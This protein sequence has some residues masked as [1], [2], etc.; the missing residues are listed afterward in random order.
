MKG[1]C[2]RTIG[3]DH[4]AISHGSGFDP[5]DKRTNRSCCVFSPHSHVGALQPPICTRVHSVCCI[6]WPIPFATS[7]PLHLPLICFPF[8]PLLLYPPM[9]SLIPPL[10]PRPLPSPSSP[11]NSLPFPVSSVPQSTCTSCRLLSVVLPALPSPLSSPSPTFPHA[12][13]PASPHHR[14]PARTSIAST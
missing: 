10:S 12:F 8:S 2:H 5:C 13:I 3:R 7:G 11:P 1:S 6:P 14:T 4:H 9:G